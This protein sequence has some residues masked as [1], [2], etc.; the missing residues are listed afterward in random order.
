MLCQPASFF[1]QTPEFSYPGGKAVHERECVAELTGLESIYS[2]SAEARM[3][4]A[5]TEKKKGTT[6]VRICFGFIDL[7]GTICVRLVVCFAMIVH[8]TD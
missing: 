4:L 3:Y 7:M 2:Q 1:T 8:L 6:R 5:G